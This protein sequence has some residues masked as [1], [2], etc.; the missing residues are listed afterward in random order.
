MGVTLRIRV[1]VRVRV[2]ILKVFV[3]VTHLARG[4]LA[5]ITV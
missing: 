4:E 3:W 1:G 2:E 5:L